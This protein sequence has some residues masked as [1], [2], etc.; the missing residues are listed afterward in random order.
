[1]KPGEALL[2]AGARPSARAAALAAWL[3]CLL[4]GWPPLLDA[5]RAGS[6][7]ASAPAPGSA[8]GTLRD[9]AVAELLAFATSFDEVFVRATIEGRPVSSY[10]FDSEA[11]PAQVLRAARDAWALRGSLETVSARS[12]PWQVLSARDQDE[13]R[14]LQVRARAG[15]GTS[16]IL[17]VWHAMI[18]AP[19][20]PGTPGTP[21]STLALLP[22]GAI[23]LR[24]F[25]TVDGRQGGETV[26]AVSPSGRDWVAAAVDSMARRAG[27]RRERVATPAPSHG[28]GEAMFFQRA[29]ATL[30]ITLVE[31]EGGTAIVIHHHQGSR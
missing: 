29:S 15:G 9:P 20:A 2:P 16:G 14:T 26:V 7:A 24:S 12:G 4:I 8:R 3:A 25:T 5:A 1:M 23:V 10:R 11:S 30:A 18:S 31:G 19:G 17:S 6:A 27:F 28:R 21:G 13:Y 22:A